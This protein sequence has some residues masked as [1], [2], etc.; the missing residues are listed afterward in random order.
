M[1]HRLEGEL[2]SLERDLDAGVAW[3]DAVR[4]YLTGRAAWPPPEGRINWI[5]LTDLET[6]KVAVDLGSAL[7]DLAHDIGMEA[8]HHGGQVHYLTRPGTHAEIVRHR[9]SRSGRPVEVADVSRPFRPEPGT[10]DCVVLAATPGWEDRLPVEAHGTAGIGALAHSLL[11]PGGWLVCLLESPVTPFRVAPGWR[12][13]KQSAVRLRNLRG[14]ARG[15]RRQ[16]FQDVRWYH[17]SPSVEAPALMVPADARAVAAWLRVTRRLGRP[18][19]G[20]HA[21]M[22]PFLFP[23]RILM[24]RR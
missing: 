10:A 1:S 21:A 5:W 11:R 4:G 23:V 9:F 16:A 13:A 22:A 14:L 3:D 8:E 17:G 2:V 19:L 18:L 24:A 7:G 6:V 20:L 15:V 12:T